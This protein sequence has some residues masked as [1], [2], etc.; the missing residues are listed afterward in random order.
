MNAKL[1][2][3]LLLKDEEIQKYDVK[4]LNLSNKISEYETI[5]QDLK[6]VAP[7]PTASKLMS[8]KI[9]ELSK[10][11]REKNCEFE[12]FK[13]QY[14]KLLQKVTDLENKNKKKIYEVQQSG[15]FNFSSIYKIIPHIY[16]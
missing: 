11:L 2:Q 10:K 7:T 12:V 3:Q 13:T 14:N 9:V 15:L 4:T 1:E 5:T 16:C 6:G 8:Q